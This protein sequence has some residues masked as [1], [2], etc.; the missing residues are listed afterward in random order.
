MTDAPAKPSFWRSL[1]M[2]GW[3]L[4]GVRKNDEYKK[5]LA[6]VSPLH[7]VLAGFIA[8]VLLVLLLLGIVNWVVGLPTA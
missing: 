5:D 2:V 6:Q 3:G 1:R 7:V 8:V 4:L